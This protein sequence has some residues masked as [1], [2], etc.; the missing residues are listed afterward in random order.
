MSATPRRIGPQYPSAGPFSLFTLRLI[1]SIR[2]LYQMMT[3]L[4]A[5]G[6]KAFEVEEAYDLATISRLGVMTRLEG[7]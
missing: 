3:D 7:A 2:S 1:E 4:K 5:K 6:L